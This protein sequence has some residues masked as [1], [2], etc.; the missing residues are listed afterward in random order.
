[1]SKD[2]RK[3]AILAAAVAEAK[4]HGYMNVTR[5]MI[6]ERAGCT[7]A[8]VPYYFGTMNELRR[9]IMSE[10]IRTREL[11]IVAQGIADG[12][13]K[14]KRVPLELRQAALSSLMGV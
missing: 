2:A 6:A 11:R 14:A 7:P 8:L 9:A 5:H 3:L 1:M 4:R 12:H 10:A 13:P